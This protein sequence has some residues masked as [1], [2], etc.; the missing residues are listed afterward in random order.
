VLK[1]DE[2]GVLNSGSVS[3]SLSAETPDFS[4]VSGMGDTGLEPVTSALSIRSGPQ[5]T[6]AYAPK[7]QCFQ[8]FASSGCASMAGCSSLFVGSVWEA[9]RES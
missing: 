6:S 5:P 8:A 4:G 7:R 3:P 2:S 9:P 1:D